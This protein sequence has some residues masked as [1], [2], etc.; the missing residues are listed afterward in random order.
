ME[1]RSSTA[2]R[3]ENLNVDGLPDEVMKHSDTDRGEEFD[4]A[5]D[6]SPVKE[7]CGT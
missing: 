1:W 5:A 3:V 4:E 2:R 6:E 7:V